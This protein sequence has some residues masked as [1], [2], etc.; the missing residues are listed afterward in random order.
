MATDT[1]TRVDNS[2]FES[3][4]ERFVVSDEPTS[5][6]ALKLT[7]EGTEH[8]ET[9]GTISQTYF[10]GKE[11][12]KNEVEFY[13]QTLAIKKKKENENTI[14]DEGMSEL[15]EY[16]YA[17][18]GIVTLQED[19]D[20]SLKD[21]EL[22]V[23]KNLHDSCT[24]PR[25]LEFKTIKSGEVG[26]HLDKFYEQPQALL[27]R[28]PKHDFK[29]TQRSKKKKSKANSKA[30]IKTFHKMSLSDVIMYYIDIHEKSEVD[31]EI[32]E[33]SQVSSE[34]SEVSEVSLTL[35]DLETDKFSRS[36]VAEIVL[37]ETVRKLGNL[38]SACHRASPQE[39]QGSSIGIGYDSGNTPLRSASSKQIIR[40][41]VIVSIFDWGESKLRSKE[42]F[43]NLPEKEKGNL[44]KN[45]DL[46]KGGIDTLIFHVA[47]RYHNQFSNIHTWNEITVRVMD[48]DSHTD[49][50]FMGQVTI[51]LPKPPTNDPGAIVWPLKNKQNKDDKR[52]SIAL[53]ISWRDAPE[54]SKFKGSWHV[55]IDK[56]SK[57]KIK[58]MISSDPYCLVIA[59][60]KG[61]DG[62]TGYLEFQQ[63][64]KVVIKSLNPVFGETLEIP[65][66]R[67]GFKLTNKLS[68]SLCLEIDPLQTKKVFGTGSDRSL[69]ESVK[70]FE[71]LSPTKPKA[72][73]RNG[74]S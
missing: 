24:K 62:E 56:A 59:S 65:V 43:Q 19:V 53:D 1:F 12:I 18:V 7:N 72:H 20:G 66:V 51:P 37:L 67:K 8:F 47:K 29:I 58:D 39:W 14:D 69:H 42:E 49:D 61:K 68:E 50:D 46:Y 38:L 21:R 55:T 36:E 10:F 54:T 2:Y 52:G 13:E 34:V 4:I 3:P 70:A 5:Y 17:Y 45:W 44:K 6:F 31:S 73:E 26:I 63:Q 25:L 57:L 48:Y 11:F 41:N 64:T 22:L 16:T 35:E 74:W 30:Q 60:S 27:S 71:Q 40:S 15:L 28:D 33:I 9:N 32:S 23:L